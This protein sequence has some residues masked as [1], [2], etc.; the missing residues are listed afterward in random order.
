M[1][2]DSLG[3]TICLSPPERRLL[4]S[5]SSLLET[6]WDFAVET[7]RDEERRLRDD[8]DRLPTAPPALAA[9]LYA[10]SSSD[11][12]GEG[13][14][15]AANQ[16]LISVKKSTPL[17]ATK[18]PSES[19]RPWYCFNLTRHVTESNSEANVVDDSQAEK[20]TQ[21]NPVPVTVCV[22]PSALQSSLSHRTVTGTNTKLQL[23]NSKSQLSPPLGYDRTSCFKKRKRKSG[24]YQLTCCQRGLVSSF[25]LM[26]CCA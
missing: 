5:C 14:P 8:A 1:P 9:S 15:R 16:P 3:T 20:R 17:T 26:A 25:T 19:Q 2:F 10:R 13:V 4:L 23:S 6:R 12:T 21:S 18:P 24:I 11:I 7:L 22:L